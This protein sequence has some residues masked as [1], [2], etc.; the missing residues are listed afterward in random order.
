[1][2]NNATPEK[3]TMPPENRWT[4]GTNIAPISWTTDPRVRAISSEEINNEE[5]MNRHIGRLTAIVLSWWFLGCVLWFGLSYLFSHGWDV[6]WQACW[7]LGMLIGFLA[8]FF[9]ALSLIWLVISG[10]LFK[11]HHDDFYP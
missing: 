6:V 11:A 5:L 4:A 1:L 2:A 7:Y 10:R 9:G 8:A 3:V